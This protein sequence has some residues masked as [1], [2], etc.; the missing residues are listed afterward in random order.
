MREHTSTHTDSAPFSQVRVGWLRRS[1]QRPAGPLFVVGVS[2]P[3]GILIHTLGLYSDIN[4]LYV[5]DT[6]WQ[7]RL[8]YID[9]PLEYPVLL[10]GF[11]W[12]LGFVP[13]LWGHFFA[14]SA[15]LAC[16]GLFI[17]WAAPQFAGANR[18]HLALAP[19]LPLYVALNWDLLGVAALVGALFAVRRRRDGLGAVLLASAVWL[20]LFPIVFVPLILLER[21]CQRRWRD[22]AWFGGLFAAIS[23][24]INI[25][26]AVGFG[27][28]GVQLRAGWLYFFRFNQLRPIE[29]NFWSLFADWHLTIAQIN[30]ASALRVIA[31]WAI[32]G[33]LFGW[34]RWSGARSS[35]ALLVPA[36][37][38]SLAWWFFI[39]KVYSP[40][41][42]LW[43][44]VLLALAAAPRRLFVTFA[45]V[46]L[47]YFIASFT[48]HLPW[49]QSVLMPAMVLRECAI[50]G[51]IAWSVGRV[52][53]GSRRATGDVVLA[54][55]GR[56]AGQRRGGEH[57]PCE[58]P[59][60]RARYG[61]RRSGVEAGGDGAGGAG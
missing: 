44:L 34:R 6:L 55:R 2:M 50:L 10:G 5:R 15:L 30:R 40:Q 26:V 29:P 18:W 19:A 47:V 27:P 16:C 59:P 60:A 12:L 24:A 48:V 17:V 42:S 11:M 4:K 35:A 1:L 53:L 21:L 37:L 39:N 49:N 56:A 46:D 38:A 28:A 25:P 57:R 23:I 45:L 58:V 3:C 31:G 22:A 51:V 32:I 7:H 36:G 43:L 13:G 33:A 14:T 54:P 9:Y 8:P 20:K 41:Y 52:A 61:V